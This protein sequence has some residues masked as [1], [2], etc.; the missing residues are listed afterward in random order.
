MTLARQNTKMFG[1]NGLL[2]YSLRRIYF[3]LKLA[4]FSMSLTYVYVHGCKFVALEILPI[5]FFASSLQLAA[6]TKIVLGSCP[7][8]KLAGFAVVL[9]ASNYYTSAQCQVKAEVS[10]EQEQTRRGV[11]GPSTGN[12]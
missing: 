7:S 8:L 4:S 3:C 5:K 11:R 1:I 2:E 9:P 10:Q 6:E 12:C